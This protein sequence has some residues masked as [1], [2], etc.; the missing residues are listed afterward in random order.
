MTSAIIVGSGAAAAGAAL[1]LSK[2]RNQKIT[3]ID[4]GLEL[5]QERADLVRALSS[6][7]PD[8]WQAS[9]VERIAGKP[10]IL[11][12]GIVPQKRTFGSDF[13]FRDVGQLGGVTAPDG[14][15]TSIISA[16]YGGFS[17]VWGSQVMPFTA[18]S[19]DSWPVSSE[20]MRHHY[21]SVLQEIPFAGE[22]DD[23]AT[24]FPL[25]R[26]PVSLPAMSA[27]AARVLSSYHKNRRILNGRGITVGKAR[28][29]FSANDC[30][31]CGLCM[32]G[33][34]Y[35]L[36]YSASQT[37][38]ALLRAAKIVLHRGYLAVRVA[39]E[40]GQAA[41][42]AV[43]S[44]SGRRER[45]T[46]DHIY[47]ACGAIGSTR[48]VANSLGLHNTDISMI[49]SQQ[50]VLPMLSMSAT[51]DPRGGRDFTLNQFNMVVAANGDP[52]DISTLHYYTF[53]PA[54]IGSLPSMLQAKHMEW[55]QLQ[56]LRRLSVAFGYLPSWHSPKLRLHIG[57]ATGQACLPPVEISRERP[58]ASQRVMLQSVLAR[59]TRSSRLLDLY[60][61]LPM[62]RLSAGAKSYHWG[63][64]FPHAHRAQNILTSDRVGRVGPWKRIHLVDGAVLPSI[65][66]MTYGL[67]V[68]ANAH[69]IAS[70]SMELS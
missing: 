59:L 51:E 10:A 64:S 67:T 38:D 36:I 27:R 60:P 53:N 33:C 4:I 43:E 40:S 39:E 23:L 65:P 61:V 22:E 63:G 70:E 42:T 12:R 58:P 50:F 68:M 37:F 32:T 18:K 2:R 41:V 26:P 46:A 57:P 13:P 14:T 8:E 29:A 16:A 66:A 17:N 56:V 28:L 47:I 15:T 69:R 49:E 45:F 7:S 62:L 6:S 54:F 35:R 11:A 44:A 30:V 9:E 55:F 3:I 52:A 34:P 19:F 24:S 31:R 5:E 20:T 1:A 25:M 21:E 48:L